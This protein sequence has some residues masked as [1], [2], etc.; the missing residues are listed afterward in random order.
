MG[1]SYF[2]DSASIRSFS[3]VCSVNMAAKVQTGCPKSQDA[4]NYLTYF[5]IQTFPKYT[6]LMPASS[7]V[8]LAAFSVAMGV[9]GMSCIL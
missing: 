1:T 3:I 2:A 4:F 7:A 6:Y 5:M 8:R 9:G